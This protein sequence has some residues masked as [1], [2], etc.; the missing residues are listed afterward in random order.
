[1][2]LAI[3]IGN[4]NVVLGAFEKAELKFISRIST[5][6]D[7]TADEISVMINEIFTIR[8]IDRAEIKAPSSRRSFPR[9]RSRWSRRSSFSPARPPSSWRPE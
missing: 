5:D 4:S 8:G 9:L 2:I 6:I 7:K 1:M 3:D